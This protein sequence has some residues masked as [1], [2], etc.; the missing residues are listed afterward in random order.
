[1]TVIKEI[2]V[3]HGCEYLSESLEKKVKEK[4]N[5]PFSH[6]FV[7]IRSLPINGLEL[8][9]ELLQKIWLKL[10]FRIPFDLPAI[11]LWTP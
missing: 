10:S 3:I 2:M 7:A 9:K 4:V 11:E 8:K 6:I 1:M 5:N